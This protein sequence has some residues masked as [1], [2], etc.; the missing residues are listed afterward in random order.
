MTNIYNNCK[1]NSLRTKLTI[2]LYLIVQEQAL[3]IDAKRP[4]AIWQEH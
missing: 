3:S 1:D 2:K 4:L